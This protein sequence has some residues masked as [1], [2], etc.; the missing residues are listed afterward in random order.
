V[1][2][3]R[4]DGGKDGDVVSLVVD[5][6]PVKFVL[7]KVGMDRMVDVASPKKKKSNIKGSP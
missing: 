4:I 6:V 7:T 3:H 2:C 5:G 1:Y